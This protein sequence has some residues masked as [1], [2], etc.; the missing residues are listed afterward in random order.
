MYLFFN[1]KVIVARQ[2]RDLKFGDRYYFEN[3]DS[4]VT[5]FT[6][7]QLNQ[8]RKS[9]MSGIMCENLDLELVARNAFRPISEFNPLVSCDL[10][11]KVKLN[12]WRNEK[13]P[14]N[15]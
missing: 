9:S 12:R 11:R 6:L 2:F 1:K 14:T 13:I 15:N 8:I 7:A 4:L 10:I 3:G 5:R